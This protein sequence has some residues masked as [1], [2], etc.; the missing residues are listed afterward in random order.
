MSSLDV[1]TI[2]GGYQLLL[3]PVIIGLYLTWRKRESGGIFIMTWFIV[4][5]FMG[6]FGQRIALF[7]APAGCLLFGI[8]MLHL[9]TWMKSG[10]YHL[11]KRVSVTILLIL[12]ILLSAASAL[13]LGSLTHMISPD[14][15][16]QKAL[17]FLRDET[18]DDSV[19]IAGW[20][21]GYWILD[22]SDRRPVVDNGFYGYTP[23]KLQDVALLARTAD[24]EEA[25]KIIQKYGADYVLFAE[26]NFDLVSTYYGWEDVEYTRESF[27]DD[28]LIIRSLEGE[29]GPNSGMEIVYH[30]ADSGIVILGLAD[31]YGV[32]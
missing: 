7:A 6:L 19:V 31:E 25:V 28:A 5:M 30:D 24:T 1:S 20:S 26:V 13:S 21:Y 3:I 18:P 14:E 29:L 17:T 15:G 32:S 9:G 27:P 10:R 12:A 16:W 8:G 11:F 2:I 23:G 22:M 4:M